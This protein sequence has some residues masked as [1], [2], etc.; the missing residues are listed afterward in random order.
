MD[1][2]VPILRVAS[3]VASLDW[4]RRV[5][6]EQEWVH[7]VGDGP[8]FMS[9]ARRGGGRLF[10]SEHDTDASPDT[11]VY[12]LVDDI[13]EIAERLDAAVIEQEWA[14]E[15]RVNDSD[16]NRFRFGKPRPPG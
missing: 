15:V 2:A 1:E 4:F 5:G 16:G 13:D 6:Y 8:A 9:V 3:A 14:R 10:L 7:R 12:V 11:L